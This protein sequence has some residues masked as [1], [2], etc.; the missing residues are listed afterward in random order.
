MKLFRFHRGGLLESLETTIE[1]EGLLDLVQY[2][3]DTFENVENVLILKRPIKDTRLPPKWNNISYYVVADFENLK[4][5]CI[6]MTNFFE[7]Y[8]IQEEGRKP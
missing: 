4:G 8:E 7:E 2:I 1:V 3:H 5:Q 6:G